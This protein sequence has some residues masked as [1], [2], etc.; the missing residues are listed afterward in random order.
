MLSV[1]LLHVSPNRLLDLQDNN[2]NPNFSSPII[3]IPELLYHRHHTNYHHFPKHYRPILYYEISPPSPSHLEHQPHPSHHNLPYHSSLT[4]PT[5]LTFTIISHHSL[6]PFHRLSE[7]TLQPRHR[8]Q[9]AVCRSHHAQSWC[10]THSIL[11]STP[12]LSSS[13]FVRGDGSGEM[14]R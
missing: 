13:L 14:E 4:S 12:A 2:F 9:V 3:T 7:T 5:T 1:L 10:F 11:D 6:F 8:L